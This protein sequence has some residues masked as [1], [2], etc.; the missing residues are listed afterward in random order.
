MSKSNLLFA[1]PLF[2]HVG[3]RRSAVVL[4]NVSQ[5]VT[6]GDDEPVLRFALQ[7]TANTCINSM[8]LP[9]PSH[10]VSLPIADQLFTLYDYA[11]SNTYF[12]NR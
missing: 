5:F 8:N 9:R 6:G 12:A 10:S 4:S 3:G 7:P 1:L 11:F 2:V